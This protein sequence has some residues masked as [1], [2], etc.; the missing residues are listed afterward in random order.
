MKLI[1]LN[2]MSS[3]KV[4]KK[5]QAECDA[6]TMAEYQAIISDKT[7]MRAAMKEAQKQAEDL[8]KRAAAMS[9]VSKTKK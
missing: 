4:D 5:W 2:D 3:V 7:R 9:K 8:S 6:R 1:K